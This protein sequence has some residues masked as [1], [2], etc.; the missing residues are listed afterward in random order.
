MSF[1]MALMPNEENVLKASNIQ[2]AALLCILP[3]IFSEYNKGA[4]L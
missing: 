3:N 2:I 4:L 1:E